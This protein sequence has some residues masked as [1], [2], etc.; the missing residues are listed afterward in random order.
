MK[1]FNQIII[2]GNL[3]RDP[4]FGNSQSG[5]AIIK[6][7]IANNQDFGQNKKTNF[8]DIVAFNKLAEICGKYLAKG[9]RVL[10]SGELSQSTW[11]D[12]DS[13]QNRSKF[14]VVANQVEFLSSPQD[15][16]PQ[17]EEQPDNNG[18]FDTS[19]NFGNETTF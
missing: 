3:T 12:K 19:F 15:R 1:H 7:S 16:K 2:E 6:F 17:M 13:G 8:V 18:G 10:I 11:K 5:T 4:Q 14:E 9:S